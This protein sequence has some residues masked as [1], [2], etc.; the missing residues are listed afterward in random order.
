MVEKENKVVEVRR[1]FKDPVNN[2]VYYI[3][4]PTADDIREADWQ[5]SKIYT[6]S[7]VD[8]ITTS[9][10][11][12]DILMRRGIIGPEF[13]QRQKELSDMISV[14]VESLQAVDNIE[15]KQQIAVEVATIREELFNWNQRLN[16]PMANT[17]EQMSDNAR[18]EYLTSCMVQEVDGKRVWDE[19]SDFLIEKNQ[20]FA[21]LA[22][23]E[24]MLYLQGLDSDFL[25]KTPEAV[26]IKEIEEEIQTKASEALVELEKSRAAED[27]PKTKKKPGPKKETTK[28]KL[29]E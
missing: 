5:Y 13:E 20:T 2:K 7:L 21:M 9:A 24:V 4:I 25:E 10:E 6:K 12:M 11:M 28:Q 15:D 29:S 22:R 23:F 26:A 19:Y 18:L 1:E 8:G 27:K 14:K 16:G 17:C 3:G